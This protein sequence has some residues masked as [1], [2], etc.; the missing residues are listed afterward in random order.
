VDGELRTPSGLVVPEPAMT[1]RFTRAT[2]PGG[3]GVN[4]TDSRVELVVD[5]AE[6]TGP[7]EAVERVRAKLGE[8]VRIVA[9]TERSQ[10]RNR[11]A[12]LER[13]AER[14]EAAAKPRR[15]RTPTRPSL[16]AE[17]RRLEAKRRRAGVKAL[18]KGPDEQ[19]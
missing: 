5:L 19:E 6:L 12:A 18:R 10:L 14:L 13:L 9:R 1:W 15:A 3:Q 8:S 16:A 7:A 2:G 4:T 11:Q 17:R